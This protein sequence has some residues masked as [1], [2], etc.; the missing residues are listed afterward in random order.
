MLFRINL[1]YKH[2]ERTP[3]KLA[4]G[5]E[6]AEHRFVRLAVAVRV[7]A[8]ATIV[9]FHSPKRTLPTL[10]E[11]LRTFHRQACWRILYRL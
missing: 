7:S 11:I 6:C 5:L 2:I 9:V 10:D 4:D 8:D 1:E 3:D